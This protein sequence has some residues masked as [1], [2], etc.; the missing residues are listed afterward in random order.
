MATTAHLGAGFASAL[1]CTCFSWSCV[2]V[3]VA[4]PRLRGVSDVGD[5]IDAG[6]MLA[7]E[8]A[9]PASRFLPE[10][11][12]YASY[13]ADADGG[14]IIEVRRTE[15]EYER[16]FVTDGRVTSILRLDSIGIMESVSNTLL[17]PAVPV[18]GEYWPIGAT[19]ECCYLERAVQT[20]SAERITVAE[21]VFCHSDG[22]QPPLTITTWQV[23]L[24]WIEKNYGFRRA[25]R[26][27]LPQGSQDAGR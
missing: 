9:P 25:I 14:A 11:G 4:T 5:A 26:R 6:T 1:V 3:S 24:G 27:S 23:G 22:P 12:L 2:A 7:P 8:T 18:A 19:H 13:W 10:P 15:N 17:L 16:E 20:V 21:Y